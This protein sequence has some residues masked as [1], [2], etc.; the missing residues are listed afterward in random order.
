MDSHWVGVWIRM[1]N[2]TWVL[3]ISPTSCKKNTSSG[4]YRAQDWIENAGLVC[5]CQFLFLCFRSKYVMSWSQMKS[6]RVMFWLTFTHSH[7]IVLCL[8][9]ICL[10]MWPKLSWAH[11]WS[12]NVCDMRGAKQNIGEMDFGSW[13]PC[14]NDPSVRVWALW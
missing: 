11:M 12:F 6:S 10:A 13:S 5:K 4:C 1:V 8:S 2:G 3:L 7:Q 14:V 9:Y